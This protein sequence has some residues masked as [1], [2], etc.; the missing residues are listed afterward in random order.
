MCLTVPSLHPTLRAIA[1][2]ER[3]DNFFKLMISQRLRWESSCFRPRAISE[4]QDGEEHLLLHIGAVAVC[5]R[6]GVVSGAFEFE[7][8]VNNNG[9]ARTISSHL[10]WMFGIRLG[11]R[12]MS[13]HGGCMKQLERSAP[14]CWKAWSLTQQGGQALLLEKE[15]S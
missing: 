14:C 8:C 1:R 12:W 5:W 2:F 13:P 6:L 4:Q 15:S 11:M 9:A 3:C 7:M 10:I